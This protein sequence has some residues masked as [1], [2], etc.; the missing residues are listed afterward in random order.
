[1]RKMFNLKASDAWYKE[2]ARLEEEFGTPEAGS[3]KA[4][5]KAL[6]TIKTENRRKGKSGG[7]DV[8]G[9]KG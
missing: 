6:K 3:P 5:E 1:M 7:K 2:A 8:A 9:P 4:L